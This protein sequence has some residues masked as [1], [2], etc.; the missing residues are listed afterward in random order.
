MR[1]SEQT[2]RDFGV[3]GDFTQVR[4]AGRRNNLRLAFLNVLLELME[5]ISVFRS[6]FGLVVFLS[7]LGRVPPFIVQE[8]CYSVV[9][10][11][12]FFPPKSGWD[13]CFYDAPSG[14]LH[15]SCDGGARRGVSYWAPSI[16]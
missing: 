16:P 6:E 9:F 2:D 12:S 8:G 11:P 10:L 3:F 14:A 7:F 5:V 13:P 4:A 1:G 15:W